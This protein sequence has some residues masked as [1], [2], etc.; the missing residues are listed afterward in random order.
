MRGLVDI[1]G[2]TS[3]VLFSPSVRFQMLKWRDSSLKLDII[4]G[5]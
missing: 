2:R 1:D 5:F 4:P 3:Q